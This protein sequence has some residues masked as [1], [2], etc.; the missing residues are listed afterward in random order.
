LEENIYGRPYAKS[1]L[2]KIE[3]MIQDAS[4][5]KSYNGLITIEHI[6]PQTMTDKYWKQRFLDD[7]HELIVHKIGNL[8]LLS[9]R[10]NSAAQNYN[11]DAKKEV[12]L[13]KHKKVSFDMTKDICALQEW[14][15]DL[16]NERQKNY[17]N[18]LYSEFKIEP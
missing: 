18:K 3:D 13:K 12:Y 14:N 4:V 8:T 11:F 5:I 15:K 2:L 9:G 1:L 6:L 10:K 17:V 7:E 16:F